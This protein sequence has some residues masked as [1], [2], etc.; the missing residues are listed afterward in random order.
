MRQLFEKS[1]I[2]RKLDEVRENYFFYSP[3]KLSAK[4]QRTTGYDEKG[5]D[6]DETGRSPFRWNLSSKSYSNRSQSTYDNSAKID[7]WTDEQLFPSDDS[8]SYRTIRQSRI[9][10]RQHDLFEESK[11]D[12]IIQLI[13]RKFKVCLK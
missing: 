5:E 10:H 8:L 4:H 13:K 3:D 1:P 11:Y 12:R 2:K 7:P 9:F 6:P